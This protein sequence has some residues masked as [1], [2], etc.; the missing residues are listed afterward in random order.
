MAQKKLLPVS[1]PERTCYSFF[2]SVFAILSS[3]NVDYHSWYSENFIQIQAR[4]FMP[5]GGQDISFSQEWMHEN[6]NFCPFIDLQR[7]KKTEIESEWKKDI[8]DFVISHIDEG[9]YLFTTVNHEHIK[10]SD[11]INNHAMLIYG[12]DLDE[13][14]IHIAD[15]FINGKFTFSKCS[16]EEFID[17]YYL[18]GTRYDWLEN[19]V[20]ILKLNNVQNTE[21]NLAHMIEQIQDY[22]NSRGNGNLVYGLN[23]YEVLNEYLSN[24]LEKSAMWDIRSFHFLMEHKDS[25]VNRIEYLYKNNMLSNAQFLH[26]SFKTIAKKV[27]SYRNLMIKMRFTDDNMIIRKIL[28][29]LPALKSNEIKALDYLLENLKNK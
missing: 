13:N 7:M 3:S 9:K 6:L 26:D 10:A 25:M 4:P 22:L 20:F 12:Y 28:N 16:F 17:A 29:E 2:S 18:L 11:F 27:Q 24:L 19:I 8:I 23:V 15:N 14:V 21:F 5:P 1:H